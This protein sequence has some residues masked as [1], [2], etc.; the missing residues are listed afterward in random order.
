MVKQRGGQFMNEVTY[1]DL[2]SER[3]GHRLSL[4]WPC[5]LPTRMTPNNTR[6]KS[7]FTPDDVN[8]QLIVRYQIAMM[9]W[10]AN[11]SMRDFALREVGLDASFSKVCHPHFS[12][13]PKPNG[14]KWKWC[15]RVVIAMARATRIC[16]CWFQRARRTD[17]HIPMGS[18]QGQEVWCWAC[19]LQCTRV[20][21]T[22][23]NLELQ[24]TEQR[25]HIREHKTLHA[26]YLERATAVYKSIHSTISITQS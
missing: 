7:M 13:D 21:A 25:K 2:H 18:I 10:F 26:T 17:G 15:K 11:P 1:P 23:C 22:A 12:N 19:C 8:L 14:P 5:T 24:M 20:P 3:L 16:L 4:C 6:V 9:Y